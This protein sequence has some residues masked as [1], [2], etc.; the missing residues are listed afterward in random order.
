M[1][2]LA[3]EKEMAN[4]AAEEFQPYLQAEA[5]RVYELYQADVIREIYFHQAQHTAILMLECA[6]V[7]EAQQVL[8]TLPLVQA[9]LISFDV[10][11]LVPYS[12]FGRLFER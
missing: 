5:A 11:P 7:D 3:L 12:G 8:S 6:G 2:I 4:S 9:G 1:R 10:I